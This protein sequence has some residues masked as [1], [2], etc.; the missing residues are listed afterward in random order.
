MLGG[1]LEREK[2]EEVWLREEEEKEGER[3]GGFVLLFSQMLG[4]FQS[5]R[6]WDSGQGEGFVGL[7]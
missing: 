5:K 2:L 4:C 1:G 7:E 3:D 6:I